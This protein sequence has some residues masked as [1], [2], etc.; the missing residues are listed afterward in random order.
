[1]VERTVGEVMDRPLPTIEAGASL[2][3]AFQL[4]AEGAPAVLAVTAGRP[5]GVVTKLD[6]LEYLAH[7]TPAGR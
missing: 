4:L 5:T 3:D 2:D 6:L 7:R 1:V